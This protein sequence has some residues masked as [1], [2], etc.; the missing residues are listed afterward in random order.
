MRARSRT[1][2]ET[3][4][5]AE[6]AADP[7]GGDRFGRSS[8]APAASA[9]PTR[10]RPVRRPTRAASMAIAHQLIATRTASS[11]AA[12]GI[13]NPRVR[14]DTTVPSISATLPRCGRSPAG[15]SGRP[16][17][18]RAIRS[19][20]RA[21]AATE[22]A[23]TSTPR[24][25]RGSAGKRRERRTPRI[26]RTS[27][28]GETAATARHPGRFGRSGE[29][30][31]QVQPDKCEQREQ[32]RQPAAPARFGRRPAHGDPMGGRSGR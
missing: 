4:R 24:N 22:T 1:G 16:S 29:G 6:K 13:A 12:S 21:E 8:K 17:S 15:S 10:T 19:P 2:A 3:I 27:T 28:S 14:G 11:S 9:V 30:E 26:R 18:S 23:D 20:I 32:R 25:H 5:R 7:P 31:Q